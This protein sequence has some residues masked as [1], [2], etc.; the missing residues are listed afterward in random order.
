MHAEESL[1]AQQPAEKPHLVDLQHEEIENHRT[2]VLNRESV[3]MGAEG[4]T[5]QRVGDH[6]VASR[7]EPGRSQLERSLLGVLSMLALAYAAI[8]AVPEQV[9]DLPI[10]KPL[11]LAAAVAIGLLAAFVTREHAGGQHRVS[12][13]VDGQ[14]RAYMTE[15]STRDF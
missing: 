9:A 6:L 7:L 5:V 8:L 12:V 2:A 14:G 15:L 11:F 13:S 1:A 3:R 10:S 4:W